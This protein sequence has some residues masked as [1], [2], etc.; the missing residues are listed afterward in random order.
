MARFLAG[1]RGSLHT[2][3][4]VLTGA[5][6]MLAF[7]IRAQEGL[8]AWIMGSGV[9]LFPLAAEKLGTA[10]ILTID[11]DRPVCRLPGGRVLRNVLRWGGAQAR[12]RAGFSSVSARSRRKAAPTAPS[13][14]R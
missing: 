10:D 5:W 1:F 4:P 12:P 2:A 9:R 13:M 7:S 8:L 6:R 11:S 14:S 3:W